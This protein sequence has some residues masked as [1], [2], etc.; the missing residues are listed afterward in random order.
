M[1]GSSHSAIIG[2]VTLKDCATGSKSV[3]A[4]PDCVHWEVAD[5]YVFDTPILGVKGQLN[6]FDYPGIDEDNLPPAHK[7]PAYGITLE[8]SE[9]VVKTSPEIFSVITEKQSNM[10]CIYPTPELRKALGTGNT[11]DNWKPKAIETVRFDLP[12]DIRRFRHDHTDYF[13]VQD[14]Q[15]NPCEVFDVNGSQMGDYTLNVCF[16]EE[17]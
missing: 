9:L 4:S 17:I 1:P 13:I 3:W 10:L 15:G 2:Y 5:A 8:G 16:G 7:A 14:D 11:V 6:V 12:G